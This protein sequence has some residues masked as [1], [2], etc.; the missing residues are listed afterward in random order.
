MDDHDS[1]DQ[2]PS[3][4]VPAI[5]VVVV[6]YRSGPDLLDCVR[7]VLDGEPRAE[8]V[9]VDNGAAGDEVT[10]AASLGAQVVGNGTNLGFAAG[11]NLGASAAAAPVLVFL[12]PDTTIEPGAL[13]KLASVVS[14]DQSVGS[15][16]AVVLLPDG[17]TNTSGNFI[18]LTGHGWSGGFGEPPPG[19]SEPFEVTYPS[20]AAMAMRSDTFR[21]LGGFCEPYFLYHEDLELGWRIRL[22]GMRNVAVPDARVVHDYEYGR[23]ATKFRHIERNRLL[24]LLTCLPTPLLL[25]VA[26]LVLALEAATLVLATVQGWLGDKLWGY[27]WILGHPGWILRRRR[28]VLGRRRATDAQLADELRPQL[29]PAMPGAPAV[30]AV[31]NHAMATWWRLLRGVFG[32]GPAGT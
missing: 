28:A 9:L 2:G 19:G 23:N 26:P 11:C 25:A 12:N 16:M 8:L 30:P 27:R 29:D 20:G 21:E 15:A 7:S 6:A 13:T 10:R 32:H 17:S 24:F 1:E 14:A 3:A 5:S 31:A 18:H 22:E 4:Q